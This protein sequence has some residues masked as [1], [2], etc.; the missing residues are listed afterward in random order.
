VPRPGRATILTAPDHGVGAD[1]VAEPEL[2]EPAGRTPTRAEAPVAEGQAGPTQAVAADAV[3]GAGTKE[4]ARVVMRYPEAPPDET[5]DH[6]SH[7]GDR[8]RG[9]GDDRGEEAGGLGPGAV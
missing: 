7:A 1:L 6:G 5:H 2:D 9:H 4:P 3:A 8:V